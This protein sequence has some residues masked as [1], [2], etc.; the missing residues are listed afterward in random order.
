MRT[1]SRNSIASKVKAR[2]NAGG[3]GSLW[4]YS[5]FRPL[6]LLAVAVA[7]SRLVK[8]GAIRRIRKGIY[9]IPR[10]TR[11]GELTP[12]AA[13][14]AAAVLKHRGVEWKASGLPAYNGLGLTTQ[15]SPVVT[16]DVPEKIY[17]LKTGTDVP[18]LL[19]TGTRVSGLTNSER[20]A[21]DALRDLHRIPDTT[22]AEAIGKMVDLF[23]TGRI[24][25]NRVAERSFNEPPRVRAVLGAIGSEIGA[26][27]RTLTRLRKSLN[28]VS[29]Y[30][31]GLANAL[32]HAREW[33]LR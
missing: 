20:V 24:S 4:T 16:F 33:R 28:P 5:D 13:S 2:I 17:S 32:P 21:L 8:E 12:D 31:F 15:V 26:S 9:Y 7:L 3:P 29:A 6:P 18:V 10:K 27:P 22:P 11:F 25:F 30:G 1:R 23:R 19:K 14:V